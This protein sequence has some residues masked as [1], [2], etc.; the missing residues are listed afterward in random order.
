[1]A[2]SNTFLPL[3]TG[4]YNTE[5]CYDSEHSEHLYS[6]GLTDSETS[7]DY[8]GYETELAEDYV[9]FISERLKSFGVVTIQLE[10]IIRPKTYNFTND[11]INCEIEVD[12]SVLY[13]YIK[14]NL[15]DFL[16]YIR[17]SY[18]SCSGFISSYSNDGMDWIIETKKFTDFSVNG[19]YLGAILDFICAMEC[20]EKTDMFI[21]GLENTYIGNYISKKD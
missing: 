8:Q 18:S 6:E 3:F 7:F 19:H 9:S 4:F 12:S 1:M 5:F 20:I 13:E 10:K 17:E 11:S 16:L 14:N 15:E 2:K 21:Y